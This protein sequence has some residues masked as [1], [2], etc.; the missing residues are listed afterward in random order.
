MKG[1]I[2]LIFF[3]FGCIKFAWAQPETP[4]ATFTI[5]NTCGSVTVTRSSNQTASIWWWQ[6]SPNG[7]STGLGTSESIGLT[8]STNLYLRA[9]ADF[10]WSSS[11]QFVGYITVTPSNSPGLPTASSVS[12]C[13]A[14]SVTLVAQAGTGGNNV[15]WFTTSTGGS[16]IY[17][18]LNFN[19]P[20]LSASTTYYAA[21]LNSN[22]CISTSRLP[23]SVTI[24]SVPNSPS[25]SNNTRCGEGSVILSGSPGANG[26]VLRWYNAPYGSLLATDNSFTTPNLSTTTQFYATTYNSTSGCESSKFTT[27][28]PVNAIV[29]PL[30]IDGQISASSTSICLGETI[31]ISSSGS[32]G[33]PYYWASTNGGQSW[34]V[35]EAQYAGQYNFQ[36][37]PTQ[38]GTYRFHLWNETICGFCWN[39]N[40]C[41]TNPYVDV[42]VKPLPSLTSSLYPTAICSGTNFGYTPVS[43]LSGSSFS[44]SRAFVNGIA[45]AATSGTGVINEV[46]TNTTNSAV[47]I[48]YVFTTTANGCSS[49][50]NVIVN[51]LPT[52]SLTS[53]L[54]PAPICSG[55]TFTYVP[56]TNVL[57]SSVSW[58]RATIAGITQVPSSGNGTINEVLTNTTNT[59]I[60]V[61]YICTT[62]VYGCSSTQN[63]TFLVKPTPSLTSSLSTT[64]LCS[65]SSFS[66]S[67][68]S[69]LPGSS[70]SWSRAFVSGV[71]Q[72]PATGNGAVNEI[73]TNV[74][75]STVQTTYVY[76]T[77]A[78]G[79]SVSQNIIV[80]VYSSLGAG[81]VGS[82]STICSGS[83][84]AQLNVSNPSG[85]NGTYDYQWEQSPNGTSWSNAGGVSTVASYDPPAL[86]NSTYYR[87]K[88]TSC[89]SSTYTNSVNIAVNSPS[90][91]GT[92]SSSIETYGSASGLLSL[93]GQTGSIQKW[94]SRIENGNWIDIANT[95]INQPYTNITSTTYFRAVVKSGVCN[96]VNSNEASL[97]IHN[98]PTISIQGSSIIPPGGTTQIVAT[99]GLYSYQWFKD[100][101]SLL[102]ASSN[103][104]EVKKPGL[105]KAS[106]KA[107]PTSPAYVTTELEIKGTVTNPIVDMN[108]VT[109]IDYLT[110]GVTEQTNIYDLDPKSYLQKTDY[111]DGLGR[112]VQSISLGA[113][114]NGADLIQSIVYDEFGRESKKYLPHTHS[115]RDGR[116]QPGALTD[117]A[118]FYAN[119]SNNVADDST[120]YSVTLFEPSPLNR[121]IKQGAPGLAWQPDPEDHSYNSI[122][123]TVKF[124][125][126]FNQAN[127]VLQWTFT[128]PTEDY[129]TTALN[130]F[131][132][133]EAGTAIAPV[134]YPANQLYKNKTKDEQGNQVIEYVDK[135]GRTLLKRVQVLS[136]NP[137]TTDTNRDTNW[138]STYYIYD[139]FGNLVCVIPPEPSERLA[140]QYFQAGSTEDS[141]NKFLKRWAFRYR[142]DGR[143]RMIMKQ[144]PGAE[145]VYMVYDDRDRLVLT[146]DGNQRHAYPS[147][148]SFTKYDALNRPIAT[149][150]KDTL[151]IVLLSHMQS[152]VNNFYEKPGSR[153]FEEYVGNNALGNMHGYSNH[154]FPTTNRETNLI[155]YPDAAYY[156]TL[157][158]YDDYVVANSWGSDY[159]Y[160]DLNLQ[161]T[162][163]GIN[164][165]QPDNFNDRVKGQVTTSKTKVLDGGPKGGYTWLKSVNYYDDKYRAIQSIA[166]NYKGGIDRV[167][168]V[169]DFGGKVLLTNSEQITRDIAWKD[170]SNLELIGNKILSSPTKVN[171]WGNAGAASTEQLP[172]GQN[173]W[174]EFTVFQGHGSIVLGLSDLNVDNYHNTID[175]GIYFGGG[176]VVRPY[177]NGVIKSSSPYGN[178]IGDVLKIERLGTQIK[179]YQ[180]GILL[181]TSTVP[182]TTSLVADIAIFDKNIAVFNVRSSFSQ[183]I[184]TIK[185]RFDY[186]H[187]GRLINTWHSFNNKPEIVLAHND[188]NELGQLIDKK[189]HSTVAD[190]SNA[191]QSVDYAYNIR[192]WLTHIN[193]A[194]LT[195]QAQEAKDYFGMEL[196]YNTDLGTGNP[197]DKLQFNG[198]INAMKWSN[199][200]GFSNQ[201]EN[202]Y[203]FTYDTLNRLKTADFKQKDLTG[204][205]LAQYRDTDGLMQS[206][207]AFSESITEYDLNGNIKFLQRTGQDGSLIDDLT[208]NYG[209]ATV[210]QSNKLVRVTDAAMDQ[211][212]FKEIDSFTDD[213]TY[214]NNGNLIYDRNKLSAEILT[215]G[216][217]ENG[218]ANWTLT[219]PARMNFSNGRVTFTAGSNPA[220]LTQ[221]VQVKDFYFYVANINLVRTSLTG[222]VNIIIGGSLQTYTVTTSTSLLIASRDTDVVIITATP[223]FTGYIESIS[224]HAV[225]A[226]TYNYLNLPETVNR[227]DDGRIRYIYTAT[228]QKLA[229]VVTEGIKTKTTDYA[230]EYIYQNDTLQFVNHEEGRIIPSSPGEGAGGEAT[231]QYHL[232]DHL[233]NVRTTFTTVPEIE[234]TL[235]TLE[236][237]NENE[238]RGNFLKYD[239]IRKVNSRL[240]DH[241]NTGITQY[242]IRLSGTPAETYGLARSI[243]V[244]P[245]DVV[246]AEVFAKYLDKNQNNWGEDVTA[247]IEAIAGVPSSSGPVIDGGSYGSPAAGTIPFLGPAGKSNEPSD[248]PRAYLN[249]IVCD[250]NFFPIASKSGFKRITDDAYEDG[251]LELSEGEYDPEGREHEALE[252]PLIEITEPGYVYIYLSNEEPGTEVY[253]DD[254]KVTH[255]KSPVIQSDDY[256]PFG[257]TFNSYKRESSL[258]NK[259]KFQGQEH[260]DDLDL[261]WVSFKWRNHMPDIGRF[262]NVDPIA[263]DY[264]YNS[265]Y[266]FSENKVVAHIELEG[267]EAESIKKEAEKVVT[268]IV[269]EVKEKYQQVQDFI[270]SFEINLSA[271]G[272]ITAGFQVAAQDKTGSGFTLNF[273]SAEI[274]TFKVNINISSEGINFD[275]S[276]IKKQNLDE[277][278][279]FK[280]ELS[281]TEKGVNAGVKHE[282]TLNPDNT[283]KDASVSAFGSVKGAGGQ[284][285][286]NYFKDETSTIATY[287]KEYQAAAGLGVDLSA[288]ATL[289]KKK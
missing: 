152:L 259:I 188:Y 132:K 229:Q 221:S 77:T 151:T 281:V 193:D 124:S 56:S 140:T 288:G 215:N 263:E 114:G 113:G 139:D 146:Q 126:E 156:L 91:G 119:G 111:F 182:S 30:P 206:V 268:P 6:T 37:T 278:A 38:A 87:R 118:T 197:S 19:T 116:Y 269:N 73:L 250:K 196:A 230:G 103:T 235:A 149:G 261:G 93:S 181:Y 60:Q 155:G 280:Q 157:T 1:F 34:N 12:N 178:N 122:D 14:G 143:Q 13:G 180:N 282:F 223:D 110:S 137:S 173:G 210:S 72:P 35:F 285:S 175:Y 264:Y 202:A 125:Y 176:G 227:G 258:E 252:S 136:G 191:K 161:S 24:N 154:S 218:S 70:F 287:K 248:V 186:D 57:G 249:W 105:Y 241:T 82:N 81:S 272:K 141:K 58:S 242:A 44:W 86:V 129:T 226:I 142:Y 89:G 133:V 120:P 67:P 28:T 68:T 117:Q 27:P 147:Y 130:A 123:H 101:V 148:W 238:E 109:K 185:R 220:V 225:T 189:L 247:L 192:G 284:V 47:Q 112:I 11:S 88:V 257:L 265:P 217:F 209:V 266:A 279:N 49:T 262:F 134:F 216:S 85:G 2:I 170:I 54:T 289:G 10:V 158:Y 45:Q 108:Y 32:N 200:Q 48:V 283:P 55:D 50:Q 239:D 90:V 183:K 232:K 71:M 62:A 273:L 153:Y 74:T 270:N 203:N 169:F 92:V 198:N 52:P 21:T 4:S 40:S 84:P 26:N 236:T 274:A 219:E 5:V 83:Q 234:E 213:Y 78:N 244:M 168:N 212:G 61:T 165:H 164:Y 59:P 8:S 199:N 104:L 95:S 128:Y 163:N 160:N 18:G 80:N 100:G 231:Y 251:K 17:T 94:Q 150:L 187:A 99:P 204:W 64:S 277:P 53:N 253:F 135:E 98:V 97:I 63:V 201:K 75:S 211:E 46:L 194:A 29:N 245:G 15:R 31:T 127:E 65:G 9:R 36:Y 106:I 167:T 228:G 233:G 76:T 255:T 41:N 179:Y 208:Y 222:S 39:T 190:A 224:V 172:A 214:D 33:T 43:N 138:A 267:L 145:P 260:I 246:S 79:C 102:G 205:G 286:Y 3:A 177:E 22:G 159:Q 174:I 16:P 131:G 275:G 107:T 42:V 20:S 115:I 7:T 51:I 23:V 121:M 237:T 184:N 171:A 162:S 66:Y 96:A 254:F 144:V 240:F 271:E 166:D 195:T 243:A 207:N 69:S 276:E 256:Y 25:V